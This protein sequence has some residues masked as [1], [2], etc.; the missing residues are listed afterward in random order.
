M[1]T[2]A[3]VFI[4]AAVAASCHRGPRPLARVGTRVVT[5]AQV[6]DYLRRETGREPNTL[7]PALAATLLE[8][9]LNEEVLLASSDRPTPATLAGEA[10]SALV[11][12]RLGEL[13]PPP[14]L[15]S[16]EALAAHAAEQPAVPAGG[17]RLL[18]RQLIL[19]DAAAARSARERVLRNEDF[20]DVSRAVSRA[21]NAASG[22]M[23][24]WMDRG[25]LPPEFEA[26]VASLPSGGVSAPVVSDAGWHVFQVVERRTGVAAEEVRQRARLTLAARQAEAAQRACLARLAA[27]LE[28]QVD[29]RDATF[30]CRNPFEEKS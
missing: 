10:R 15:P 19:P 27:A 25:Q 20:E 13:C 7:A 29:C 16:D 5:V 1:R 30:P 26:A 2:V 6:E 21:P 14:P 12:Q 17:E 3:C 9:Y 23:L 22:G 11:R 24:G 8:L 18:L 4:A 28:I